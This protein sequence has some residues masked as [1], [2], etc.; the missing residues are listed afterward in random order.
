[1]DRSRYDSALF[2]LPFGTAA[3]VIGLALMTIG[4]TRLPPAPT[5]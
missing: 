1:M 4:L 5:C 2:W 3:A